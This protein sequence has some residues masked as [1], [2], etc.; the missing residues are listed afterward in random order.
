MTE[1]LPSNYVYGIILFTLL[2]VAGVTMLGE[3]NKSDPAILQTEQAQQFNS[4]FNKL[5]NVTTK[6]ESIQSNIED[7]DASGWGA[8]G[9]LNDLISQAWNTISLLGSGLDFMHSGF[10]G[11]ST[12]FGVPSW[13]PGLLILLVGAAISFAVF[14]AIFQKRV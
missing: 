3:L 10:Q 12:V 14:G 7:T 2:I 9:V 11:I 13:V 4:S 5:G 1:V 8:F 6:V